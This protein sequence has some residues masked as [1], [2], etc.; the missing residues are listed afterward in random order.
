MPK[1]QKSLNHWKLHFIKKSFFVFNHKKEMW[2][3]SYFYLLDK[4]CDQIRDAV[5]DVHL[6]IE[7]DAKVTC[8]KYNTVRKTD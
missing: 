4:L 8:D 1:T 2:Y 5:L 3:L 6:R 7:P